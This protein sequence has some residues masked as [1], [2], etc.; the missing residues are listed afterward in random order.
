MVRKKSGGGYKQ[1][2]PLQFRPGVELEPLIASFAGEHRLRP[3][4]ACKALVGLAVTELD[5]RFYALIRELAEAMG[6]ARVLQSVRSRPYLLAGGASQDGQAH[7][8]RPGVRPV[9]PVHRPRLPGSQRTRRPRSRVVVLD[10]EGSGR[11][12]SAGGRSRAGAA[13]FAAAGNATG[14]GGESGGD[15]SREAQAS[16]T[17]RHG[18]AGQESPT[19]VAACRPAPGRRSG[20]AGAGASTAAA[21]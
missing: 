15:H 3:N 10:G 12:G 19:R 1:G 20:T 21:A 2:P 11:A 8:T 9:H 6:G 17:P 13:D 4:E 16:K 7:P 5:R 18:R 14:A